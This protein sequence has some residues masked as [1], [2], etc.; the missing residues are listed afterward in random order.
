MKNF[1]IGL[2]VNMIFR[3]EWLL[4]SAICFGL[5]IWL[6][7]PAW[8]AYVILGIWFL[9]SLAVTIIMMIACNA[10]NPRMDQP[11]KNPYARKTTDFYRDGKF[12]GRGPK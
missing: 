8:I 6:G 4:I 10:D 11:L 3:W 5:H 12:V 9:A 1:F 7:I 2:G